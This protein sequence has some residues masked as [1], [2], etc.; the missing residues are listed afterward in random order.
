MIKWSLLHRSSS[1]EYE[2][3]TKTSVIYLTSG[4]ILRNYTH[5]APVMFGFN[6][7]SDQLLLEAAVRQSHIIF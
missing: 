5:F 3:V 1:K 7:S 4:R 6:A 2:M